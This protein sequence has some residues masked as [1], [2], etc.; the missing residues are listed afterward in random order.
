MNEKNNNFNGQKSERYRHWMEGTR[1]IFDSR[2]SHRSLKSQLFPC[3]EEMHALFHIP[4]CSS[5]IKY[6]F[7]YQV[8]SNIKLYKKNTRIVIC[9]YKINKNQNQLF[10]L[11]T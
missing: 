2:R 6:Y 5:P 11:S 8:S 4:T 9:I 3:L 7:G 10:K 1:G